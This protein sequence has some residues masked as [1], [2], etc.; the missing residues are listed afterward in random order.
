MVRLIKVLKQSLRKTRNNE[1]ADAASSPP[2]LSPREVLP[3][4]DDRPLDPRRENPYCRKAP[5]SSDDASPSNSEWKGTDASSG[6]SRVLYTNLRAMVALA[7][8]GIFQKSK[9]EELLEQVITVFQSDPYDE[10]LL[11]SYS[12]SRK[13]YLEAHIVNDIIL[14]VAFGC[15][16]GFSREELLDLAI[17]AFAHDLGMSQFEEISRKGQAL[18]QS[19]VDDVKQHP[20]RSAE[21][22]RP[23]F[24]EKIAAVVEAIH[25]RENGQGYPRGIPGSE[26]HLWAKIIAVCDTF[27]ALTH[28]RIFRPLYGPYEAMKIVIKKKDV[29]FDDVVVKRF[30]NFLSI[31]PIGTIVHL[32][33]GEIAMVVAAHAGVPTCPVVRLL[34]NEKREIEDS[35]QLIDLAD[36]KLVYI[37]GVVEPEKEKEI[38][39]F[40]KPRGQVDI[41]ET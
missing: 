8:S 30:V 1:P 40:L 32:N 38:V 28:P 37:T 11:L 22:I 27:E 4:V 12:V 29:L 5:A 33:S 13:A 15:N 10:L 39:A 16:L 19:E 18:T 23:V 26:I 34:I 7:L 20:L 14:T 6:A 36:R 3:L 41:D 17:C 25:E 9:I 2:L 35:R 31:Y 21:I 24:G